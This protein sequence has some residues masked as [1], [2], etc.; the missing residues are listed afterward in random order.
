MLSKGKESLWERITSIFSKSIGSSF[1]AALI[2]LLVGM[3]TSAIVNAIS[4]SQIL[5]QIYVAVGMGGIA[6]IITGFF[7]F[8]PFWKFRWK[9]SF[10]EDEHELLAQKLVGIHKRAKTYI[11]SVDGIMAFQLFQV[12]KQTK[13][14]YI[15][16]HF[17]KVME[18]K[19]KGLDVSKLRNRKINVPIDML[20]FTKHKNPRKVPGDY[21]RYLNALLY[22]YLLSRSSKNP[23]MKNVLR[24]WDV[25]IEQDVRIIGLHYAIL[26][27]MT[28]I[29]SCEDITEYQILRERTSEHTDTVYG[30][31]YNGNKE[32]HKNRAYYTLRI[33]LDGG[34]EGVQHYVGLLIVNQQILRLDNKGL[35]A[36]IFRNILFDP[37][38]FTGQLSQVASA[39]DSVSNEGV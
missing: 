21:G 20:H 9:Y 32:K 25:Y 29:V 1:A 2:L 15:Q 16:Y 8:W 28:R 17:R 26:F 12:H 3:I 7:L 22:Q 4:E 33:S 30:M 5:T 10:L 19:G 24:N 18:L 13:D 34:P 31:V 11:N 36:Q 37:V 23:R 38:Y 6:I 27:D 14:E 39:K 35:I